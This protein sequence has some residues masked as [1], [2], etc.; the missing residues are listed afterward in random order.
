[1]MLLTDGKRF[2]S[3]ARDAPRLLDYPRQRAVL[4]RRLVLDSFSMSSGKNCLRLSLLL[5]C[6][7]G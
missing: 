2:T 4:A 7:H 3:L 6:L 5:M 1:M